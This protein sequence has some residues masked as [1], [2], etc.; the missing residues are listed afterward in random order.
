M[1]QLDLNVTKTKQTI[2]DEYVPIIKSK[3]V[4]DV[5]LTD[6]IESPANYN[7]LVHTLKTAQPYQVINL[8]LNNGGGYVDSAF[9]IIDAINRCPATVVA[10]LSGTVASSATIIALS[11]DDIVCSKYLSFMIHNYSTG[12]QGKGHELKAYQN[13]T[14]R[15]LNRAFKE[16][17]RHFLTEEEMDK[18]IDGLDIWLSEIEVEERWKR[19]Q[20]TPK[21]D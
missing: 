20:Q 4:I 3:E 5:Y 17:Y 16:I 15:E 8:Y 2:W 9:Y 12:M 10:H 19:R 21:E 13:F 1:E 7:E 18:V 11:C 14:D 6:I